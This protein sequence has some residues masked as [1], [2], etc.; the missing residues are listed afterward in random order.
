[1]KKE[2]GWK[3]REALSQGLSREPFGPPCRYDEFNNRLGTTPGHH[4]ERRHAKQQDDGPGSSPA[5]L[6]LPFSLRSNRL[7]VDRD[8]RRVASFARLHHA[9]IPPWC[10]HRFPDG[11]KRVRKTRT[12]PRRVRSTSTPMSLVRCFVHVDRLLSGLPSPPPLTRAARSLDPQSLPSPWNLRSLSSR[13]CPATASEASVPP[14]GSTP[15]PRPATRRGR[16]RGT[17]LSTKTRTKRTR[18]RKTVSTSGSRT[19]NRLAPQTIAI[20][21]DFC[22]TLLP[23]FAHPQLPDAP[24]L[25][26][27]YHGVLCRRL[28]RAGRCLPDRCRRADPPGGV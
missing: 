10:H 13:R 8:S 18:R 26:A 16:R 7:S 17:R 4:H 6:R 12:T 3:T 9:H 28:L 19:S 5:P 11:G 1:M 27:D 20:A 23:S 15:R 21:T 25:P 24:R 22:L 14:N 2:E